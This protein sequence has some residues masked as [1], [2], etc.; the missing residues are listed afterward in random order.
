MKREPQRR[1]CVAVASEGSARHPSFHPTSFTGSPFPRSRPDFRL[2]FSELWR[3]RGG[4]FEAGGSRL[5]TRLCPK[6]QSQRARALGGTRTVPNPL[7]G[8]TLLRL[9]CDTAAVRWRSLLLLSTPQRPAREPLPLEPPGD[10]LPTMTTK[11]PFPGMNPFF[12]QPWRDA[13]TW[14]I[15]YLHDTLQEQLPADLI[16]R[17]R[18]K[19]SPSA[20]GNRQPLTVRISRC[21]HRGR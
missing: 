16:A 7:T 12:E 8:R 3:C 1:E 4:V 20:R 2:S 9:V 15:T 18:R 14:L 19:S 13:H 21:A 5:G 11:N 17:R 10:S 6:G